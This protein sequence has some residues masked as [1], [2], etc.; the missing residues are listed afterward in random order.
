[1]LSAITYKRCAHVNNDPSQPHNAYPTKHCVTTNISVTKE[2]STFEIA[3][4]CLFLVNGNFTCVL[5]DDFT[6]T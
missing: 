3:A 4:K 1:M 5:P 2:T 6:D